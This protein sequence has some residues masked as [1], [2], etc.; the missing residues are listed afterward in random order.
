MQSISS[1]SI[2]GA[3]NVARHLG[4]ALAKSGITIDFIYGRTPG[5]AAELAKILGCRTTSD[6]SDMANSDLI[7][8]AVSDDALPA[9]I[10][11]LAAIAPVAATSGTANI[12]AYEHA[13]PAGVFYPLQTFSRFKEV[14]LSQ[15]PFF[16]ESS[17][18]ALTEQLTELA[19]R[20]SPTVTELPWE[21]R[22]ELH[23]AAVFVNNFTN[24]LVDIAQ[25]HLDHK[26]LS[27]DWLKPLLRETIEK[28]DFQ[29]AKDAQTGPARRSDLQTITKHLSM[30]SGKDVEIYRLL[31]D[32]IQER[33]KK[34]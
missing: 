12:L 4:T 15:T 22:A 5:R 9:V 26:G 28:L 29:L 20:L 31:S 11:Q 17:D 10:P 27:F 30:L 18:A 6:P 33:F 3:G 16:V 8:C 14:D 24:H 1:I 32:S 21:L 19:R 23:L 2:A 34:P 7:L 13:F 25:Q